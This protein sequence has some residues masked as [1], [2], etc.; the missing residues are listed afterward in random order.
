MRDEQGFVNSWVTHER[1]HNTA[2]AWRVALRQG[3][4]EPA[5]EASTTDGGDPR[6]RKRDSTANLVE[7]SMCLSKSC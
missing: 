1:E 2:P 7:P 3:S 4:F 6:H 5:S